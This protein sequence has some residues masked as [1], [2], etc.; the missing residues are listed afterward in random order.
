M[1]VVYINNTKNVL[2][3]FTVN[4]IYK[5]VGIDSAQNVCVINDFGRATWL[6]TCYFE[7]LEDYKKQLIIE[8]Y[9]Q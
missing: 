1:K 5:V 3:D 2:I 8:R 4:K 9:E 7:K 6:G